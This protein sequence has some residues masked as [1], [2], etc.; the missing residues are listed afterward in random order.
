MAQTAGMRTP[1]FLL[2]MLL[3]SGRVVSAAVESWTNFDGSPLQAE[4]VEKRGTQVIFRR[5]DGGRVLFPYAKL[6]DKDRA[7]V[8]ALVAQA[9]GEVAA[10]EAPAPAMEAKPAQGGSNRIASGLQGKLVGMRNGA[11]DGLTADH[12]AGTKVYGVYF[13]AAWCP[14]CRAFT[15]ELVKT[16]NAIKQRHPEF[17]VI[18]VS[19]DHDERS[20]KKYMADYRMPWPALRFQDVRTKSVLSGYYADGIPNL[21]FIDGNGRV[22]SKSYDDSGNY[23]GP[24]KVLNDIR[25]HFRM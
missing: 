23:V 10:A 14:P 1:V 5:A 15:P 17:E 20:M 22:L 16:Y 7:R 13:S 6:S 18:F 12:L 2:L 8:D 9:N 19:G 24:R 21:V 3:V 25:Q 11:V 4:F